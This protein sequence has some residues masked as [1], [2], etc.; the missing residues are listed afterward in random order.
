VDLSPEMKGYIKSGRC[1]SCNAVLLSDEYVRQMAGHL[2][3]AAIRIMQ[4]QYL[5]DNVS[6]I[7]KAL[8]VRTPRENDEALLEGPERKV[9]VTRGNYTTASTLQC[10]TCMNTWHI[11]AFSKFATTLSPRS[12]LLRTTPLLNPRPGPAGSP[13]GNEARSINLSGCSV[14][15]LQK[16]APIEMS[17]YEER[18]PYY[19]NT[20]S[21][22]V[23]KEVSLSTS[24]SK[25]VTIESDKLKAHNAGANINI[26]GFAAIQGQVQDQIGERY[27]VATQDTVT[28][29]ETTR[30]EIPPGSAVE[31]VI[32]WIVVYYTGLAILG[33]P[34]DARNSRLA[35]VPY[36]VPWRLKYTDEVNNAPRAR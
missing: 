28:F 16:T 25:S 5:L 36:R 26:I 8:G 6:R 20:T 9:K 33:Q 24:L 7:T 2:E 10:Q 14:T 31:H 23:T 18:K 30:I 15:S 34:F 17:W 4:G 22:S 32:H 11:I 27:S 3:Q 29:S 21:S 35:E 1:P 19:N 13:S 12:Q